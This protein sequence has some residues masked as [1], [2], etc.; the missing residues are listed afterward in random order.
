MVLSTRKKGD[1]GK[2]ANKLAKE[3]RKTL[4]LDPYNPIEDIFSVLENQGALIVR[5]PL[6]RLIW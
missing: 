6:T 5:F 1:L 4:G 3:A 2:E